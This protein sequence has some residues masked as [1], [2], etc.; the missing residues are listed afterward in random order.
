VSVL[1]DGVLHG[2]AYAL[3][4]YDGCTFTPE[5]WGEFGRGGVMYATTSFV[6][7][8][9]RRCV[10]S[11]LREAGVAPEGSPWAGALSVPWVLRVSGDLLLAEPHPNLAGYAPDEGP[12]P[13]QDGAGVRT[14]IVD[15][16]I[17]EMTVTGRSGITTGR[18]PV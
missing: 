13:E 15:A 4:D 18:R 8:D 7:R 12:H 5:V 10:M 6:D 1:H 16:G 3:G 14:L 11:W 9:G 2:V 17:V